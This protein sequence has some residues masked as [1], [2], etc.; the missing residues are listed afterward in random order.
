[1]Q[2]ILSVYDWQ[3]LPI[4]EAFVIASDIE[5][6]RTVR[7]RVNAPVALS[8]YLQQLDIVDDIFLA[9]VHGM[10]EIQFEVLG[11]Y[12]LYATG[13]VPGEELWFDTLDGSRPDVEPVDSTSF[14]NIVQRQVRNL[15]QEIMEFKRDQNIQN[16]MNV[17]LEAQAAQLARLE[18]QLVASGS[19]TGNA[20][21]AAQ[22]PNAG[23]VPSDPPAEPVAGGT[24][25]QSNVE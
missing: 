25:G 3:K 2:R 17:L 20:G 23:Q 24:S 5:H 8:L 18:A 15:D 1:M 11:G 4:G 12:K 22:E 14:T 10:D 21:G 16:R 9:T 19:N 13:T 6:Q 7:L